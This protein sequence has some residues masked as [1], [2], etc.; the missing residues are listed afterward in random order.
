[1]LCEESPYFAAMFNGKFV[2]TTRNAVTIEEIENVVSVRS[3]SMLLEW[4]YLGRINDDPAQ[5]EQRISALIEF[6][7]FADMCMVSKEV[8]DL[9]RSKLSGVIRDSQTNSGEK[10]SHLHLQHVTKEHIN[11]A[12][13][14]PMGNPVRNLMVKACVRDFL[15]PTTFKFEKEIRETDS[16]AAD[17][18]CTVKNTL[19]YATFASGA[20]NYKDP[21]NSSRGIL[22]DQDQSRYKRQ[23]D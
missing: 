19:K 2:E 23:W 7:R 13:R 21:F 1:M 16:F 10:D 9:I 18:L 17:L 5:P 12:M 11:S 8:F 15:G 6:A 14:L 22:F 20:I 3:F 4:I